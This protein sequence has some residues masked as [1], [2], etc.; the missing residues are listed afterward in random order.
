MMT[1]W[2]FTDEEKPLA[3]EVIEKFTN[4][5]G[6]VEYDRLKVDGSQI[7][8]KLVV[9][10]GREHKAFQQ[11]LSKVRV[12]MG[13]GLPQYGGKHRKLNDAGIKR[14]YTRQ[15]VNIPQIKLGSKYSVNCC[16]NCGANLKAAEVGLNM[17]VNYE[18]Q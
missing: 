6:F 13:R 17:P 14:R 10:A 12:E 18:K 8:Q 3:R 9:D 1:K 2:I 7:W 16:P 5:K 11:A 4:E 15:Q